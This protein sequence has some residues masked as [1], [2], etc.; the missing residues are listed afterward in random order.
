[1]SV[2]LPT[3]QSETWLV[4]VKVCEPHLNPPV[5]MN[6]LPLAFVLEGRARKVHTNQPVQM[7]FANFHA[8]NQ[9]CFE[10]VCTKIVRFSA[11]AAAILTAPPQNRAIFR[12]QDPALQVCTGTKRLTRGAIVECISGLQHLTWARD[13]TDE[14]RPSEV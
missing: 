7:W 14:N 2:P 10:Y 3:V 12:H 4:H 8:M 5:R 1:M 11:V 13:R 9:P 6:F